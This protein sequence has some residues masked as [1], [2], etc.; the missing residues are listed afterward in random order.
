MNF[1]I[2][3]KSFICTENEP[4]QQN[5]NILTYLELAGAISVVPR[6]Y[7]GPTHFMFF[8]ISCLVFFS[9]SGLIFF[10]HCFFL[11]SLFFSSW[12]F[13]HFL[14]DSVLSSHFI[15]RQPFLHTDYARWFQAKTHVYAMFSHVFFTSCI[16][17]SFQKLL[18]WL[19]RLFWSIR[20]LFK[21]LK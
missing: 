10:I 8:T 4:L 6:M 15:A 2:Q 3:L 16:T 12:F 14:I 21:E 13:L 11:Y 18:E 9:N 7:C 20:S 19:P 1:Q 5:Y 17:L